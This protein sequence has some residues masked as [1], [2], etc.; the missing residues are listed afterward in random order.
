MQRRLRWPLFVLYALTLTVFGCKSA[1]H[2]AETTLNSD[3]SI[4]RAVC[5]P[6]L[7]AVDT[8]SETRDVAVLNATTFAGNLDKLNSPPA[9]DNEKYV[10][11]RGEFES[12]AALPAHFEKKI[13]GL[14]PSTLIRE[15]RRSDYVFVIEH[16]WSETLTDVVTLHDMHAA[17]AEAAELFISIAEDTLAEG[18]GPEYNAQPLIEWM[19]TEGTLAF[20]RAC[21][22]FWKAAAASSDSESEMLFVKSLEEIAEPIG[23]SLTDT[24]GNLVEAK[25]L[26]QRLATFVESIVSELVERTDGKPLED[27]MIDAILGALEIR[28]PG[29]NAAAQSAKLKAVTG[30]LI[31]E[32]YGGSEALDKKSRDLLIRIVGVYGLFGDLVKFRYQHQMPGLIVSTT[33]V[34]TADDKVEWSFTGRHAFPYGYEM[35]CRSVEADV[36]VQQK[37]L[38]GAPIA[39]RASMLELAALLSPH[40]TLVNV[41]RQCREKGSFDGFRDHVRRLQ[42]SGELDQDLVR[43]AQSVL[44]FLT[45]HQK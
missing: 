34:L 8:W 14:P 45:A 25:I 15:H 10:M 17:A 24:H 41:L 5:Q 29:D 20:I 39:D 33:G 37:L 23:L 13:E 42:V 18:L 31:E 21:D 16:E 11:A 3:G 6:E 1:Y 30:R 22:A 35:K 28:K 9:G 43:D 27:V 38:G 26:E 40:P 36:D 2:R 4:S 12:V 32:K 19:R 44:E 7:P